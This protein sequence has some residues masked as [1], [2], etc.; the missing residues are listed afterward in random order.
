MFGDRRAEL[1]AAV[2][3]IDFLL[4]ERASHHEAHAAAVPDQP[5]DPLR[6]DA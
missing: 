3:R 1:E 6:G 4:V 2:D 5:F